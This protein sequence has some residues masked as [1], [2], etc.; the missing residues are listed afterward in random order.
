MPRVHH[1]SGL[2]VDEGKTNEGG[3]IEEEERD[4]LGK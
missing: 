3:A 2:M 1:Q 4:R